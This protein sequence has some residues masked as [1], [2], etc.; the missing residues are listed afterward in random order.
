M[1]QETSSY[2]AF[3]VV[4]AGRTNTTRLSVLVRLNEFPAPW[5][6]RTLAPRILQPAVV[7]MAQRSVLTEYTTA[8]LGREG[9]G[10]A[11]TARAC[12]RRVERMMEKIT[13]QMVEA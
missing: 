10:E 13:L 6:R 7:G 1:L 8:P 3:G 12:C 5:M 11:R 4:T 2:S 9:E